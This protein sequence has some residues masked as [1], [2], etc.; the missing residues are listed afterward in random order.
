MPLALAGKIW[1]AV[2]GAYER[3]GSGDRYHG[4]SEQRRH[5][6]VLPALQKVTV[7]LQQGQLIACGLNLCQLG[8]DVGENVAGATGAGG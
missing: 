8:V 1:S 6:V 2:F 7:V 4:R 5:E 3:S